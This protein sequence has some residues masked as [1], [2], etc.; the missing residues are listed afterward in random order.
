[1]TDYHRQPRN[2]KIFYDAA[3]IGGLV[4]FIPT[5]DEWKNFRG[6][7]LFFNGMPMPGLPTF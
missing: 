7:L 4:T 6:N 1:M 2:N 3:L 5:E